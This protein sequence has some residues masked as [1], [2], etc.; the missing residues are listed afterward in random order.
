MP[1]AFGDPFR[2]IEAVPGVTSVFSGLPFFYVRGAPPG[3]VGYF[4]DGVRVPALFHILAG[5]AVVPPSLIERVDLHPGGYPAEYGRFTG[6]IVTGETRAPSPGTHAE[7][8]LRLIDAGSVV[9]APLPGG[10]GSALAGAR[11]SYTAPVLSLF[12]SDLRFGYWDYQGRVVLD[13]SPTQHLT[14]FA[15]GARDSLEQLDGF[16]R[17]PV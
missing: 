5:P 10:L 6:G 16:A 9:E 15:F 17:P 1:G 4:L 11:F 14:I 2:A 8:T 13:L 7:S 12:V 3:N